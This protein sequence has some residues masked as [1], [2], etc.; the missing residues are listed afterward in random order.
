MDEN[1][2]SRKE[3]AGDKYEITAYIG[4]GV[5]WTGR[6][7][8]SSRPDAFLYGNEQ[9]CIS[10]TP[11]QARQP[12]D[13]AF[14]PENAP[15]LTPSQTTCKA[16]LEKYH[17]DRLGIN[18]LSNDNNYRIN[19]LHLFIDRQIRKSIDRAMKK[20][21]HSLSLNYDKSE[22]IS[23]KPF[24]RHRISEMTGYMLM[25]Y[26]DTTLFIWPRSANIKP[27]PLDE[28]GCNRWR[29]IGSS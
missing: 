2:E 17:K 19:S 24:P 14:F 25:L 23:G 21:R 5:E 8:I 15:L 22:L 13:C 20:H 12:G 6:S 11:S 18:L 27:N 10:Q 29:E 4:D 16:S 7:E 1:H 3:E 9:R 28:R 26:E